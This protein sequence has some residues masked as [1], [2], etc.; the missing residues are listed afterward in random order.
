MHQAAAQ[1][2]GQDRPRKELS[3]MSQFSFCTEN[4]HTQSH[5]HSLRE[6]RSL[7]FSI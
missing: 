6:L 1:C 3:H 7:M 5:P 4:V 2:C